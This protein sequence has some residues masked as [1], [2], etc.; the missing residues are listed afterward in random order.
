MNVRL[1]HP[2]MDPEEVKRRLVEA[3]VHM[4]FMI[5]LYRDQL[6][7]GRRFLH[8]HPETADSWNDAPMQAL[9]KDPRVLSGVG[10]TCRHGMRLADRD[11][12]VRP[13]RKA[14]RWATSAEAV[15]K[16][17]AVRCWNEG[18]SPEDPRRHKHTVLEG[19][20]PGSL[21][22]SPGWSTHKKWAYPERGA[23]LKRL[24]F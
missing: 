24:L 21:F 13:V 12:V 16:R 5:M 8:E 6:D 3:R 14:T 4:D 18:C 10:H 11:G 9:L 19:A 17:L 22:M 20:L 23:L 1:N 7:R 2:R 15:L